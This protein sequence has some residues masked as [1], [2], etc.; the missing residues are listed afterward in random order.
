MQSSF[1]LI[2]GPE[3]WGLPLSGKQ[4]AAGH[5]IDVVGSSQVLWPETISDAIINPLNFDALVKKTG[6]HRIIIIDRLS[7]CGPGVVPISGHINKS[8][9]NFLTA[10]T[11]YQ[12][13]PRFPDQSNLYQ[14][15]PDE[16]SVTV[17]TVGP[18]RFSQLTRNDDAAGNPISEAVGL[19]APL[20]GY[21]GVS[22]WAYGSMKFDGNFIINSLTTDF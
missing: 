5:A 3:A 13:Y 10:V 19:V 14:M 11:P 1:Y 2:A 16:D 6:A 17:Q 12:D 22:I 21:L 20:F 18:E 15:H 4:T 7:G 9:Y 8:G